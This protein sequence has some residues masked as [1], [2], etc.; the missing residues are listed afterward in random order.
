MM[1]WTKD[2][3]NKYELSALKE[4]LSSELERLADKYEANIYNRR[5]RRP[6]D[7]EA[8]P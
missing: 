5:I 8:I 7:Q 2:N 4:M 1:K 6:D 3:F